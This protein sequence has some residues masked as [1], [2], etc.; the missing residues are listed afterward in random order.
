[1]SF[2][3]IAPALI[4]LPFLGIFV[5]FSLR[6]LTD[7]RQD[8][9]KRDEVWREFLTQERAQRMSAMQLGLDEVKHLA[10]GIARVADAVAELAKGISSHDAKAGERHSSL[11]R[12]L[13]HRNHGPDDLG[14]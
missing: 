6:M 8:S 7:F 2:D 12:E 9:T 4:Q 11:L 10:G 1:M 3:Q 5:W 14:K 13:G